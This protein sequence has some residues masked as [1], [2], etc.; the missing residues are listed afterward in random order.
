MPTLQL[1]GV[2]SGLDVNSLVQQL[3]AVERAPVAQRIARKET[4]IDM[5]LSALGTLKGALSGL[6]GTLTALRTETAFQVRKAASSNEEIFTAAPGAGAA[7][8]TYDVEVVRLASAHKLA[9]A[10]F[11][12]GSGAAVGTGTLSIA[13]GSGSFDVAIDTD[14]QT[15][16][17]IRDAINSAPDNAG[18]RATIISTTAGSRLVLTATATGAAHAL[19]VTQSGGDGGLAQLVYD[20]PSGSAL[21]ELE[22]ANDALVRVEGFDCTSASNVVS[23]VIEGVTLNL[24]TA[25]PGTTLTLTV[26]DDTAQARDRVRKFVADFNSLSGTIANLRR[27]D[28]ASREAGPLLGDS[29]LS[30]IE[31]RLR[32]LVGG[33]VTGRT[34]PYQTL[35]SVGI[36]TQ[37]DGSLSLDEAKLTAALENGF[38]AVGALFGS[39]GGVATRV[40]DYLGSVL[41]TGAQIETR[42]GSL[43]Q[44]KKT[45][46]T[47]KSDLDSRM[48]RVQAR[49]R[50][51]FGALDT[52]LAGM[53]STASYLSQQLARLP[54]S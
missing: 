8:G 3:V 51:Q 34:G 41:G 36:T 7:P 31:A 38:D 5:Q 28:P 20:P 30:G 24:K 42:V 44:G 48:E 39:D 27:Y 43:Q 23:G 52:L 53:Q 15:L 47:E 29:M 6:Q 46:A 40:Y 1:P 12:E 33:A 22:P 35:A 18:V 11:A 25:A 9:S 13:V 2:G 10:A 45:I 37:R 21:T 16:A 54:K 19:R 14:H 26:S 17:G 50:A 32:S 49:Y 4:R